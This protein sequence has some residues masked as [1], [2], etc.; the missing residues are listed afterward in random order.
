MPRSSASNPGTNGVLKFTDE[1]LAI[2]RQPV[3]AR[4]LVEAGPGTGKT[5]VACARVAYLIGLGENPSAILIVSFTRAAIREMR[6]RI[7]KW[8][9]MGPIGGLSILT[10][11][12]TAFR[13]A[14][15]AGG[16]AAE[17]LKGFDF[18]MATA[19]EQLRGGQGDVTRYVS[20]LR[21]VLVDES[22][23]LTNQRAEFIQAIIERLP[24]EAGVTILADS[25]QAIYGFTHDKSR[26]GSAKTRL[27]L[28]ECP[29]QKLG[30][31]R[32]DLTVLHRTKD[33]SLTDLFQKARLAL[34]ESKPG[35]ALG[36]VTTRIL[37][38]G[39]T[40][41]SSVADFRLKHGDLVLCRQRIQALHLAA[42]HDSLHRFRLPGYP[43]PL[44][45]WI[46]LCLSRFTGKTLSRKQFDSLWS[47]NVPGKLSDGWTPD[48]AYASLLALAPTGENVD[49]RRLRLSLAQSRPP[50]DVCYPEYGSQGPIFSTIHAAKGREAD[51]V[52]LLVPH[53]A[54]EKAAASNASVDS[55]VEEARVYYV[56]ATRAR[57]S[58]AHGEAPTLRD[59]DELA[60]GNEREVGI[61][62]SADKKVKFQLGRAGDLV[63]ERLISARAPWCGD[64]DLALARQN[65]LI[66]I[67]SQCLDSGKAGTVA[68][69]RVELPPADGSRRYGY[70]FHCDSQVVAWAGDPLIYDLLKA[71]SVVERKAKGR[72]FLP[73]YINHIRFIGLRSVVVND[74]AKCAELCDPF[75]DSGIFLAPILVGF[76]YLKVYPAT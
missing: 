32:K 18:T 54:E 50:I 51:R 61:P 49:M 3:A 45:P 57:K 74:E 46:A 65:H 21:H 27:F 42:F 28:R 16:D 39:E 62:W 9:G 66:K 33:R 41:G 44:V 10:V 24:G 67:W 36:A 13:F 26:D 55:M 1:Q 17:L 52:V 8:S 40:L 20:S 19:I 69:Q 76:S 7:K 60:P 63:E 71:G 29:F 59:A 43:A 70:E 47:D 6:D 37:E 58:F 4:Q 15:G 72:L 68:A 38:T 30:I 64:D 73:K 75:C 25:C 23:D 12:Q 35:S 11:D 53:K 48:E 5:A 56:G 31:V 22:Q 2:I 34:A 14:K